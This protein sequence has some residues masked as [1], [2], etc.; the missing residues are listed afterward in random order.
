M[1]WTR[2]RL[3][4]VVAAVV[5]GLLLL[6][7]PA[8]TYVLSSRAMEQVSV[9]P[10]DLECVRDG[11][12]ERPDYLKDAGQRPEE[13]DEDLRT[14][15]PSPGYQVVDDGRA[16]ECRLTVFVSNDGSRPVRVD[17]LT[18]GWWGSTGGSDLR[19]DDL[20]GETVTP[21]DVPGTEGSDAT[22]P[23]EQTVEPGGFTWVQVGF[24]RREGRCSDEDNMQTSVP[25]ITLSS[26]GWHSTRSTRLTIANR[27]VKP[28]GCL[29]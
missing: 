27:G 5:V 17:S 25:A 21:R 19:A 16:V 7:A 4:G 12:V 18:A 22:W 20:E 8:V 1:T 28:V 3:L 6:V 14:A 10:D 24:V 15:P 29:G 2:G 26:L 23:V 13:A 11:S 9:T